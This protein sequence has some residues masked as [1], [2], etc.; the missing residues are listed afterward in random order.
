MSEM[1]PVTVPKYI[2]DMTNEERNQTIRYLEEEIQNVMNEVNSLVSAGKLSSTDGEKRIS[3]RIS[4]IEAE[5]EA[6]Y[7]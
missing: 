2:K 1:Y 3:K 7:S 4:S 6:R 5:I